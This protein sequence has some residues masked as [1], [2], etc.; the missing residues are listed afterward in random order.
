MRIMC[1]GAWHKVSTQYETRP[2][3]ASCK[4]EEV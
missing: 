3:F 1:H 4:P 2:L